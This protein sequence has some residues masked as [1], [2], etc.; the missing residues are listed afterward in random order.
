MILHTLRSS[1]QRIDHEL[2]VHMD[3]QCEYWRQVL[4]RV[5]AC[6]QFLSQRGLSFRGD[7]ERLGAINNGN[8]LGIIELLSQFDPFLVNHLS[9]MGNAGSGTVSYLSKTIQNEFILLMANKVKMQIKKEIHN[10]Q[11]LFHHS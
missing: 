3:K 10:D 9:K 6:V 4:R 11:I 7:E 1:A 5:V 8:F 2:L